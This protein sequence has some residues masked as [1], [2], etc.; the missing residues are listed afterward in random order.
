MRFP[1][2]SCT[3]RGAI[4]AAL[5]MGGCEIDALDSAELAEQEIHFRA[6]D[7]LLEVRRPLAAW[8]VELTEDADHSSIVG[9]EGGGGLGFQEPPYYDPAALAGGRLVLAAFS[10]QHNLPAGTHRVARLHMRERGPAAQHELRLVVAADSEGR[11]VQAKARLS[12]GVAE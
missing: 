1:S 8:Q 3:L 10:T 6:Y 2:L 12:L 7:L 4:C 9:I 11:P 5:F